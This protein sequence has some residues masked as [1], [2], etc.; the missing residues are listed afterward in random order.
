MSKEITLDSAGSIP[1]MD[2][3]K[4]LRCIG[5]GLQYFECRHGTRG[6]GK[7]FYYTIVLGCPS[8]GIM[9]SSMK[10]SLWRAY[11]RFDSWIL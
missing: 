3:N 5:Q 2:D 9:C 7:I 11:G 6:L 4:A 10:Y 8:I 1:P